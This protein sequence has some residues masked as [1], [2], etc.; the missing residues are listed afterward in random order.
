[1]AHKLSLSWL[2]NFLEEACESLRGNM[3]ASEFKEYVIAMLFLK[4]VND[5]FALERLIRK[6][7]LEKRGVAGKELEEGLEREEAYKFFVPQRARWEKIKHQ[8]Q[9]VGSELMKAFAELEEKNL[10][11]LEGVLKPIDFNKTF[12]KNNKRITDADMVELIGHFDK[13]VLTDDNLEFPDLLVSGGMLIES[14]NYVESKYGSARKLTLYGQEKNGTTWGLCKLN[15]LFHDILDAQIENGDT[16]NEPHDVHAHLHGGI[17]GSEVE[18]LGDYWK[19]YAGICEQLFVQVK[20]SYCEFVPAIASKECVKAFLDASLELKSKHLEFADS[21][22]D[23]WEENLPALER[24]A[25]KAE[26]L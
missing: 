26:R 19:S 7:Q 2:E 23:W 8:K 15:M 10:G 20:N 11:S 3:D 9:E 21:L 6:G 12:G 5:Q 22:A 4:R 13:V 25:K 18:A 17:P 16:L 14:F 1:M 24:F